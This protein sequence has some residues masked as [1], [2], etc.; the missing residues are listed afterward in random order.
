MIGFI[1]KAFQLQSSFSKPVR[2]V[3]AIVPFI[4]V[5][6]IY[7]WA[8]H[9]RHVENPQDKIMPT[10]SQLGS[11]L[12]RAAFEEDRNGDIRLWKDT[13]VSLRRFSFGV[14]IGSF[15]GII[16]GLFMGVFPIFESLFYPFV[17]AF[18][19]IPPLALL[20]ILFILFGVE[21]TSKIILIFLGISPTIALAVYLATKEVPT[22][23]ITKGFTLGASTLEVVFKI[24]FRVIFPKA[25][26]AVRL[27]LG[28]AWVYLIA[29]EGIAAESGL[30][31]RI[32][33]VRR[34]L[35]MDIIIPYVIWIGFLG[36]CIDLMIRLFIAWKY[37]WVNK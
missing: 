30:G 32:F 6:V 10:I 17:A 18:A 36:F 22:Q 3:L 29:A 8:S 34:Y 25:L 16:V 13:Y 12:Y 21:E 26:D 14:L 15:L 11:G 35:A 33:V 27:S 19:K 28:A 2:L 7:M 31:Y 24:I 37:P 20:P 1:K 23:L 4:V 5:T 9:V